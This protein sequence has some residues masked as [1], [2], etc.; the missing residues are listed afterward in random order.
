LFLFW[1]EICGLLAF[2]ALHSDMHKEGSRCFVH[3]LMQAAV[4]GGMLP[5]FCLFTVVTCVFVG[6]FG[7]WRWNACCLLPSCDCD[8]SWS[9]KIWRVGSYENSDCWKFW[10]NCP[11]IKVFLMASENLNKEL[12]LDKTRVDICKRLQRDQMRIGVCKQIIWSF[13]P[14][15]EGWN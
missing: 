11:R 14:A 8:L 4:G 10:E 3:G 6:S 7:L 5:W 15:T 12:E 1:F 9:T 13:C 2:Y